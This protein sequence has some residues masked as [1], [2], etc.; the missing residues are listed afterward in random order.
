[1]TKKNETATLFSVFLWLSTS[2]VSYFI[3]ASFFRNEDKHFRIVKDKRIQKEKSENKEGKNQ[4][5]SLKYLEFLIKNIIFAANIK[6]NKVGSRRLLFSPCLPSYTF[7]Q[8][9][10]PLILSS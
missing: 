9:N 10:L 3:N 6:R 2:H 1:M 8:Q 4:E 5:N 7:H